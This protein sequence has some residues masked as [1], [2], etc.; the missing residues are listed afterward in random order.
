MSRPKHKVGGDRAAQGCLSCYMMNM[1]LYGFRYL[2]S[3]RQKTVPKLASW[4]EGTIPEGLVVLQMPQSHRRQLRTDDKLKRLNKEIKRLALY[5]LHSQDV[6]NADS[7]DAKL[8]L[9]LLAMK[10][11]RTT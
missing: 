10:A 9:A 4:A 8:L 7:T 6:K 2:Y 1:K 11:V 3:R 5:Q